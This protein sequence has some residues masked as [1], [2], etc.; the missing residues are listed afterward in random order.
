MKTLFISVIFLFSA[1]ILNAQNFT[2]RTIDCPE[3]PEDGG[4]GNVHLFSS[5]EAIFTGR[6]ADAYYNGNTVSVSASIHQ[7]STLSAIEENG[8]VFAYSFRDDKYLY[9]WNDS[10]KTWDCT[11]FFTPMYNNYGEI[12][13]VSSSTALCLSYGNFGDSI[14]I[15]QYDIKDTVFTLLKSFF[16]ED[17]QYWS[18]TGFF[19]REN[20]V[21]LSLNS[22]SDTKME[23]IILSYSN[24][25]IKQIDVFPIN[26]DYS[27]LFDN[28]F[29]YFSA[30]ENSEKII[31]W[32]SATLEEEVIYTNPDFYIKKLFVLSNN[33]IIFFEGNNDNI[34]MLTVNTGKVET[35]YN[36]IFS[37][38]S[39]NQ[40]LKK[41]L[42]VGS[43]S[44]VEMTIA[45]GIIS[46]S[47]V[48]FIKLYPNPATD[49]ITIESNY[50]NNKI[51]IYNNLGQNVYSC[52]STDLTS[53]INVSE[54]PTGIYFVK[55]SDQNGKMITTKFI[56]N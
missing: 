7:K 5:G 21:I 14:R 6:L 43:T 37:S 2:F 4:L 55:L 47:D 13:M 20:D 44:I 51:E 42:F 45:D 41:A 32:N 8:K 38:F 10:I 40:Y 50:V 29:V 56:K 11:G 1:T 34:K 22:Y 53:E 31:K 23:T 25:S 30:G 3:L 9:K 26:T 48:P 16:R 33:E 15:W 49:K 17:Q 28:N 46:F 24:D 52:Y 54:Y 27:Y 39:Y 19:V 36:N 12:F 35:I 18:V